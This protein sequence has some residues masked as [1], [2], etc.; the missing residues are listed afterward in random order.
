MKT[1]TVRQEFIVCVGAVFV[2]SVSDN[3]VVLARDVKGAFG[4]SI[5]RAGQ[6]AVEC[7]AL[8]LTVSLRERLTVSFPIS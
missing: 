1:T 8:G 3:H 7:A 6:I 4:T 5:E 2:H